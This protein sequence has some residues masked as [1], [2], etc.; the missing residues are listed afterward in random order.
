[1]TIGFLLVTRT[2]LVGISRNSQFLTSTYGVKVMFST[3]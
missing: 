2:P 1:M 3:T